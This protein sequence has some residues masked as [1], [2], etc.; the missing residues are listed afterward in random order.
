MAARRSAEARGRE[1][2][3]LY[4]DPDTTWGI[5][6][7]A[8]LARHLD[9]EDVERGLRAL[10]GRHPHLGEIGRVVEVPADR[11][12]DAR[13]RTLADPF[14]PGRPLVRAVCTTGEEP[15]RARLLVAVHHGVCDGL[16]LLSLVGAGTGAP[17][18]PTASGLGALPPQGSF[19]A[20]APRRV[21]EA[22]RHPPPR[23]PVRAGEGRTSGGGMFDDEPAEVVV[24]RSGE[25]LRVGTVA[26][27]QALARVFRERSARDAAASRALPLLFVGASRRRPGTVAPDRQTA[28]LRFRVDPDWT[29]AEAATAFGALRPEPDFPETSLRGLG[30]RLVRPLRNRLGSTAMVSNLGVLEGDVEW[31]AMY[32]ALS[33]PAAV[34]VGLASTATRTT[35]SVRTR[36]DEF[37]QQD[38]T[39]LL[40]A[41]WGYLSAAAGA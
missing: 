27:C 19:L 26:L 41:L 23:F 16:G 11:W 15:G 9:A 30:P 14:Q 20:T 39:D 34:S 6:V 28:Y 3:G 12:D 22:L 1:V 7:E 32:P 31:L 40:E 2:V 21:L 33:G 10:S 8:G 24:V 13:A 17:L 18:L 37:G 4:G 35:L 36:R 25:R 29:A 5:G 38:A